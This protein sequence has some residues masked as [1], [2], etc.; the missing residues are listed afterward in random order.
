MLGVVG[1]MFFF[2][3]RRRHTRCALVTGFQTSALPISVVSNLRLRATYGLVG[4]DAIGSAADRF[5]YLSN[6]DMNNEGRSAVFGTDRSYSR[7]GVSISRYS[8]FDITWETAY[9]TN[10]A[11]EV[12]LFDKVQI[13]ADFF[14]EHRKNILMPRQYIPS[15]MGLSS[16]ISANL[17]EAIGK[18]VDISVDYSHSL[19]SGVWMQAL[20]NFTY[21]TNAFEV[22]E[23]PEYD[24]SWLTRVGYP[25]SLQRGFIAERLFLDDE[26]V[27]NAPRQ[28]FGEVRGGDIKYLDVNQDGEITALDKVPL[29]YPTVPEINYGFGLSAGYR[30]VDISVFFQGLAR[31]SFWIDAAATAPFASYVYSGESFPSGTILQNQLLK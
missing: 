17:G 19:P 20:A 7:D 14:R 4:N 30:G 27:A 8:N 23:E 9:K 11:I 24:E 15:T 29:G 25:I 22:Y 12:G 26:E 31:E 18:G 16:P 2:S 1:V 5:F 28:N 6:V 13:M 3:S 21:A 10:L